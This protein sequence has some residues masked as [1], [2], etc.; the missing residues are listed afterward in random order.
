[1]GFSASTLLEGPV[2]FVGNCTGQAFV[3]RTFRIREVDDFTPKV[4]APFRTL[5]S[6]GQIGLVHTIRAAVC[7]DIDKCNYIQSCRCGVAAALAWMLSNSRICSM[8]QVIRL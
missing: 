4:L 5:H 7:L 3:I 1:M 8:P 2:G 6:Y